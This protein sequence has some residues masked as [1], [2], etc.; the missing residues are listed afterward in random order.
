MQL[1]TCSSTW[2]I[3]VAWWESRFLFCFFSAFNTIQLSEKLLRMIVTTSAVSCIADVRGLKIKHVLFITVAILQFYTLY[4]GISTLTLLF[5]VECTMNY[6]ILH[7]VHT[8]WIRNRTRII[9]F[10][11]AH[12]IAFYQRPQMPIYIIL[13]CAQ[14]F[15][16]T[17]HF[18]QPKSLESTLIH[19]IICFQGDTFSSHFFQVLLSNSSPGFSPSFSLNIGYF[20]THFQAS[21]YLWPLSGDLF[22]W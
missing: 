20:F 2:I 9:T 10:Y 4:C 16:L 15:A 8:E 11:W 7:S 1:L 19:F 17:G 18:F 3:L 14:L 5:N 21:R 13:T 12:E 22:V 6:M